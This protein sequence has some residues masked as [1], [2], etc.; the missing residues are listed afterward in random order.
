MRTSVASDAASDVADTMRDRFDE[1]SPVRARCGTGW[2]GRCAESAPRNFVVLHRVHSRILCLF[3]SSCASN[4]KNQT[5]CAGRDRAAV[6][7]AQE[8]PRSI[9]KV[10]P[11]GYWNCQ[12]GAA[13]RIVDSRCRSCGRLTI[14][15]QEPSHVR[16]QYA[17]HSISARQGRRNSSLHR[18]SR[19]LHA[20]ICQ[21][22]RNARS[23]SVSYPAPSWCLSRT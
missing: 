4:A 23:R 1:V 18:F 14:Q 13:L 17:R 16:L 15:R 19:K 2:A 21:R 6:F 11:R 7:A 12:H 9:G 8:Q 20:W 10:H 22:R 5:T 3:L